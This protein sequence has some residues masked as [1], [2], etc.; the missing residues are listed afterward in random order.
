MDWSTYKKGFEQYLKL[1]KGLA[2]HS[3][4]AYISD[5]DKL[6]VFLENEGFK[7][8][9]NGINKEHIQNFLKWINE[10]GLSEATQSRII[11]GLKSFYKYLRS[12]NLLDKDPTELISMPVH[13]RKLP[14]VLSIAEVEQLINA[15]DRT[16]NTGERNKAI[17]ELLYGCGLRATEL[18]NLQISDLN[19][20]YDYITI[21]GKGDKERLVPLGQSAKKQ[22][23]IYKDEVRVHME[24]KKGNDDILFL[25]NRGAKLTRVMVFTIIKELAIKAGIQKTI[26]PHTL[27]HSFA[28]HLVEGG[29]DLR[30]VQE[31]LGHASINTTE[32]YT[33]LDQSYLKD[34]ITQFHPRS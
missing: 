6:R 18:I 12:E 7:G 17:I 11:S 21:I 3:V 32:I 5:I 24:P 8:S 23:K 30:A 19:F 31:M 34:I 1:E 25:N 2:A 9:I 15:I 33:H 27:R 26:S 29:A 4:H 14:V 20:N 10:L 13:P 16:Q 22:I 28:T